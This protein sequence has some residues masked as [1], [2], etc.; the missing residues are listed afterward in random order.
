VALEQ[1]L[2][3]KKY[4][5]GNGWYT[6]TPIQCSVSAAHVFSRPSDGDRLQAALLRDRCVASEPYRTVMDDS[7]RLVLEAGISRFG[8]SGTLI[9]PTGMQ[10]LLLTRAGIEELLGE[11]FGLLEELVRRGQDPALAAKPIA[12]HKLGAL[13]T[14][15]PVLRSCSSC[16]PHKGKRQ[17]VSLA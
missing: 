13:F 1:Y 12:L 5:D 2:T 7:R 4:A 9:V 8:S 3:A 15:S 11:S 14:Y 16:K 17:K 6:G 10:V